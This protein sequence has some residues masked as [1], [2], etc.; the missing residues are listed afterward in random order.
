MANGLVPSPRKR[1]RS[2]FQQLTQPEEDEGFFGLGRYQPLPEFERPVR[3]RVPGGGYPIDAEPGG[4]P[5]APVPAPGMLRP[6]QGNLAPAPMLRRPGETRINGGDIPG[7]RTDAFPTW[8]MRTPAPTDLQPSPSGYESL[9]RAPRLQAPESTLESYAEQFRRGHERPEAPER[10]GIGWKRGLLAVGLGTLAGMGGDSG[11]AARTAENVLYGPYRRKYAG[12]ERDVEE[13]ESGREEARERDIAEGRQARERRAGEVHGR[14][15]SP[16]DVQ[17]RRA[18]EA[19]A[20]GLTGEAA[21]RYIL[22]GLI[23]QPRDGRPERYTRTLRG[24]ESELLERRPG[25]EYYRPAEMLAPG[26]RELAQPTTIIGVGGQ[27]MEL[28]APPPPT[29]AVVSYPRPTRPSARDVTAEVNS[30]VE[31]TATDALKKAN[32]DPNRAIAIVNASENIPPEHK[33]KVRNRIR[34]KV[35]PGARTQLGGV[36]EEVNQAL[37]GLTR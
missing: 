19:E 3:R 4:Y 17:A 16:G 24:G 12:Y 27:E 2:F 6:G 33:Q 35:R 32:G 11:A 28:P 36:E 31:G 14:Y 29:E 15:E 18:Q 37:Q 22:T 8:P 10:K 26:V 20:Q 5:L 34:E 9:V 1:S 23:A 7:V 21:Q 25:E 13:Y 30:M